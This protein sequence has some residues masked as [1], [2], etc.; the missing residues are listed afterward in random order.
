MGITSVHAAMIGKLS[1]VK[2]KL[3]STQIEK[4]GNIA[5]LE[6]DKYFG[7]VRSHF[8]GRVTAI[9]RTL[10]KNPKVVNDSPYEHG[11]LV[12]LR[13]SSFDLESE[14][15]YSGE[16]RERLIEQRIGELKV[17]CF[18]EYPDHEM[19][20]I[21][22]ECSAVLMRLND[23]LVTMRKGELVHLVTDDPLSDIEMIRW[24]DQSKQSL[25]ESRKEGNLFHFLVKKVTK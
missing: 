18:S 3:V 25:V 19:F 20:E 23:L 11:W 21:G 4:D 8:T 14:G 10:A 6:S 2:I 13:P 22:I 16:G 17:R 9:N 24:S 7:G 5:L 12:K 15:L 1:R